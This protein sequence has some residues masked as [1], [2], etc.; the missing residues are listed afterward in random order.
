MT[1]W[2]HL[3]I[4]SY[5]LMVKPLYDL[6]KINQSKLVWT[7]EAQKF[8]EQLKQELMI[9]KYQA[10]L[11]EQDDVEIVLTTIVNPASFLSG[12]LDEPITH[13]CRETMETGYS[14][15]PDP[16]EESLEDADES[17]Y[18]EGSSFAKQGQRKAGYAVTTTQ[19]VI[20]SKPLPP[21][22][23]TQKAQIIALT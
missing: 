2:C 8:F 13:D 20:E 21:G 15:R 1:G 11:V 16:K 18:T 12:T 23:S 5:G 19:Q 14:N 7:G 4:Y 10:V 22:T 9:L 3:W 6:I 17:W